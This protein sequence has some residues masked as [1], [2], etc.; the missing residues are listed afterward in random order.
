MKNI[1]YILIVAVFL[2]SIGFLQAQDKEQKLLNKKKKGNYSIKLKGEIKNEETGKSV[3]NADIT[4]KETSKQTIINQTKANAAG[5]YEVDIPKGMEVEVKAQAP[6]LFYDIFKVKVSL[7]DTTN[8]ME[9]TFVLPS[10]LRL[11]LNFPSNKYDSPYPFVLDDN[12]TETSQ[13]WEDALKTVAEDIVKYQESLDKVVL[14]GHT[15]DVGKDDYNVKLGMDRVEFVK[16][17]LQ[18]RGVSND[19]ME[20]KSSGET[21]LLTENPGEDKESWRKRC[22]RVVLT[23]EMKK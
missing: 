17:E 11:R 5:N 13:A 7:E 22:R 3:P 2:S 19:L 14:V 21:E 9:H 8:V 20:V 15:D 16:S 12:G 10:E 23:K 6:E 4:V 1:I 18:K